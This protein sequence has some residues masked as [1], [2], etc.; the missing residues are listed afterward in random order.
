MLVD[1]QHPG[2]EVVDALPDLDLEQLLVPTLHRGGSQAFTLSERP[3][4]NAPMMGLE[5]LLSEGLRGSATSADAWKTLIEVPSASFTPVLMAQEVKIADRETAG[6]LHDKLAALGGDLVVE[7]LDAVASGSAQERPQ[8]PTGVTY[9]AKI[10]KAEALIDWRDAASSALRRVRA[11][12]PWP[13]AE[14]TWCGAQ[15][16]IWEAE[17]AS[18]TTLPTTTAPPGTVLAASAEGI[19]VACGQGVLRLLKLQLAG[20]RPLAAQEFLKGQRLAGVSFAS[21]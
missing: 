18:P 17:L 15:L 21:P 7:V 13:I 4:R 3:L 6:T 5:D 19:D 14:T 11:F 1:P 12:N 10:D 9:A 20:R 8:P 16:R 2:T